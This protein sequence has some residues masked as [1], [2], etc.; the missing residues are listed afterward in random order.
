V[1]G[2]LGDSATTNR[3][4]P[5]AVVGGLTF[6]QIAAGGGYGFTCG[7]ATSGQPYC[8]GQ[9]TST[10]Y[11]T[12]VSGTP[13]FSKIVA[14]GYH[15]CGLTSGGQAYC[16][17]N[18]YTGALGDGTTTAPLTPTTPV[19]VIGGLA[20]SQLALGGGHT[21]GLSVDAKAYCWGR[22]DLSQLGAATSDSVAP[23]P[24]PVIHLAGN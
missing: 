24:L 21:C 18:N 20:F 9:L 17:G 14:G 1:Y 23:S 13:S 22:N 12:P 16:W 3:S 2:Q 8:W 19:A 7:L 6:S 5:V 4:A 15:A 10:P 11:P